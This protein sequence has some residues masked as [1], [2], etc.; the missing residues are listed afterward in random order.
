M[1]SEGA[2]G[3]CPGSHYCANVLDQMCEDYSFNW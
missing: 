2:T 3:A 1:A